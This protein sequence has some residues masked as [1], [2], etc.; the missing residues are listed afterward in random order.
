MTHPRMLCL[1]PLHPG[2]GLRDLSPWACAGEHMRTCSC[3]EYAH[4]L[5][6]QSSHSGEQVH[7]QAR[8]AG[9]Q[10]RGDSV[11]GDTSKSH[12]AA[13]SRRA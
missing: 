12:C 2:P 6:K 7:M 5:L 4:L 10:S 11:S 13:A 1:S 9:A 3:V 8:P